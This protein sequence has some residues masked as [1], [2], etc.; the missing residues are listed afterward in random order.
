M[1]AM[2]P[3]TGDGPLEV[4]KE[5]RGI[6]MRVPSRV[7][8]GSSSSST[9]RRRAHWETPSRTSWAEVPATT[10]TLPP[11]VS[12]PAFAL[13]GLLPHEL[14]G[15]EVVAYP[16]TTDDGAPVLGPGAEAAGDAL[17]I[18]LLAVLESRRARGTGGE[19]VAVPVGGLV[20]QRR[21]CAW[22]CW[23]G[24]ATRPRATSAGPAP[25][26]RAQTVDHDTVATT[27]AAAGDGEALTAFVVGA[28]LGSFGFHWRS[29]GPRAPARTPGR[30]RRD[31]RRRLGRP[32][33]W[34]RAR[35]RR[36]A[37]PDAGHGPVQPQVAAVARRAGRGAGRRQRPEPA[38]SGTSRSWPSEGFGGVLAV[39][40]ASAT[41]PRLI[42]LDYTPPARRPQG[43]A[44][45]ARRQGHHLRHRR[46]L[47]QARRG[48]VD[49]EARHDRWRRRDGRDGGAGPDG[50][51][52]PRHRTR[53]RR[54]ERRSAATPCAPAT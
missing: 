29:A 33:A 2:K 51:P 52:V 45:G 48:H 30:A 50:L 53:A 19:V 15:V 27:V 40:Q 14:A 3:R 1:A 9:P 18:D 25:R 26:W 34:S 20:R 32:R 17:G 54:R 4:T 38:R 39:G 8:A 37:G 44:G 31:R 21:R 36:L 43:A 49:D 22:S 13:S 47:D 42:R 24:S 7:V 11:Q 46:P 5:G 6:V 41:P 12:P 28:M 23:S 35:W 10:T 16:F